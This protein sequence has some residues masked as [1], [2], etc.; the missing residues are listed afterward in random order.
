MGTYNL[1]FLSIYSYVWKNITSMK[2]VHLPVIALVLLVF[3][4]AAIS[5]CKPTPE[6]LSKEL[7]DNLKPLKDNPE[8]FIA[9]PPITARPV[10]TVVPPSHLC[11]D[12]CEI[13][14]SYACWFTYPVTVCHPANWTIEQVNEIGI[15]SSNDS[16]KANMKASKFKK[17]KLPQSARFARGQYECKTSSGPWFGTITQHQACGQCD[18]YTY[19]LIVSGVSGVNGAVWTGADSAIT[20]APVPY[21]IVSYEQKGSFTNRCAQSTCGLEPPTGASGG[22]SGYPAVQ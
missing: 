2:K 9:T 18:F 3:T 19:Q 21:H 20:H 8:V 7:M 6:D 13:T 4:I 15:F 5:S 22:T 16:I 17:A 14:T 1:S 12:E 10:D 11:N